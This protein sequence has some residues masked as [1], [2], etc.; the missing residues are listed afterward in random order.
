MCSTPPVSRS[1]ALVTAHIELSD[2][3]GDGQ[4]S[5]HLRFGYQCGV[6][7]LRGLTRVTRLGKRTL[8]VAHAV[9][10]VF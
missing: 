5:S 3:H 1:I 9:E 4:D 6:L 8:G 2:R 10:E 7:R